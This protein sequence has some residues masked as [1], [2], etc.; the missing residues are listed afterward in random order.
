MLLQQI[1]DRFVGELLK[2][3]SPLSRVTASM[4]SHVSAS[5]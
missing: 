2:K 5:N 4:A 3:L 1:L